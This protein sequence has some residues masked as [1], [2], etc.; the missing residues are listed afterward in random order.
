MQTI[1]VGAIA[2]L[3]ALL[4]FSDTEDSPSVASWI[5]FEHIACWDCVVL[6]VGPGLGGRACNV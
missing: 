5:G 1:N 3:C 6:P 2:S 4:Y